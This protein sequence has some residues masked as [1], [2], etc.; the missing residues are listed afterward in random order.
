M[1]RRKVAAVVVRLNHLVIAKASHHH[2]LQIRR[3]A[4]LNAE[5]TMGRMKMKT[6]IRISTCQARLR[7]HLMR[8]VYYTCTT[9]INTSLFLHSLCIDN[10]DDM[11]FNLNICV[12]GDGIR[13]FYES[14]YQQNPNSIMAETWLLKH[15]LLPFDKAKEVFDKIKREEYR[16]RR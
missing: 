15:G 5:I 12:Q 16:I 14:L 9:A 7:N 10:F 6:L 1:P 8:Y 11:I 13:V 4:H 3:K 2:Q